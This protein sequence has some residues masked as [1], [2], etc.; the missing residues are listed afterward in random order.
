[1][2]K[3]S[4][5]RKRYSEIQKLLTMDLTS[6]D[7]RTRP[8]MEGLVNKAR[9]ER[10]TVESLIGNDIIQNSVAI[11]VLSDVEEDNK[12]VEALVT[13]Q[14]D[15]VAGFDL[16][17]IEKDIAKNTLVNGLVFNNDSKT[18]MI[19]MLGDIGHDIGALHFAMPE[20]KASFHRTF[21]T[22]AEAVEGIGAILNET[23]GDELKVI[24][25]RRELL[26][27]SLEKLQY[28]KMV[29]VFK[30]TTPSVANGLM[31]IFGRSVV[32]SKNTVAMKNSIK[33]SDSTTK[34]EV[35]EAISK[36]FS[37]KKKS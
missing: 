11:L 32:L 33:I 27:K 6:W 4:E 8:S 24:H 1:M 31:E 3:S 9:D 15:N 12:A 23:Y 16:L 35:V 5:L 13:E 28:E 26:K 22:T 25:M 36:I 18:K 10:E 14:G 21:K 2:Q 19:N 20:I 7:P 30:N 37:K 17:A 29:F 34:E